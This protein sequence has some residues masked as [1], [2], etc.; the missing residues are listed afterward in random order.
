VAP[1]PAVVVGDHDMRDLA[2]PS[3]L[4]RDRQLPRAGRGD[5]GAQ[6]A[7]RERAQLIDRERLT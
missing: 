1:D 3:L 6:L 7:P 5:R 4:E 2:P